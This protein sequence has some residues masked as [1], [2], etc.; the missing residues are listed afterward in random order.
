MR[1]A[2]GVKGDQIENN[3]ARH[4]RRKMAKL[5]S[6]NQLDLK[7]NTLPSFSTSTTGIAFQAGENAIKKVRNSEDRSPN[8]KQATHTGHGHF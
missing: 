2:P 3:V 4:L 6:N 1:F 7:C 8:D 5:H